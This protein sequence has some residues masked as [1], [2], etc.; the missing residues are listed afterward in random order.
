[1]NADEIINI[2]KESILSEIQNNPVIIQYVKEV[3]LVQSNIH[4]IIKTIHCI[5]KNS[6]INYFFL[7]FE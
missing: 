4:I 2:V 3:S 1:M 6:L 7:V 5:M